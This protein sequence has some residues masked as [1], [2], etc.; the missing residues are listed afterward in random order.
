MTVA[1]MKVPFSGYVLDDDAEVLTAFMHLTA[2]PSFIVN[3]TGEMI[4]G[5]ESGLALLGIDALTTDGFSLKSVVH[6]DE[7]A[8]AK[9]QAQ[10]LLDGTSR[11]VH[12]E[13]RYRRQDGC[14]IWVSISLSLIRDP[15]G[16]PRY[17]CLQA[18]DIDHHKQLQTALDESERRWNFAL[19]SAG[20]GIWEA[21]RAQDQVYYSPTWKKLRGFD[22]NAIVKSSTEAWMA[23]VHPRD[24]ERVQTIVRQQNSGEIKRKA[25]E[26]RERH[27]LGH[28][29]WIQSRGA[30]IEFDVSGNPTRI[31]GTDTDITEFKKA[32]HRSR[33]LAHRLEL[34][35]EVSKI[36]VF[37]ADLETGALYYDDP[38]YKLFG[39]PLT[40]KVL[41]SN[42]FEGAL[43][44]DDATRIIADIAA[45]V[46]SR[47]TFR[48]KFRICR[49]D[50]SIRS[51][52]AHATYFEDSEG[53][54]K[55]IG[56]NWD[57][58]EDV[59]LAEGLQ[60]ANALAELR[61][62][63][64][65]LAKE[66]IERQALHDPLTGLPNRRYLEALLSSFA[67]SAGGHI[68]ALHID[69]DGFKKINDTLGH[70]A[71]DA[72]LKHVGEFL[73]NT[74][75]PGDFVCRVGG[76]E[77]TVICSEPVGHD[78]LTDLAER[79][80]SRLAA[81]LLY[82][83]H[84]CHFGCSIGIAIE[85]RKLLF[86]D[87][88]L[89]NADSA[90]YRAKDNGRGRV[91][92]FT[93]ALR[94]EIALTKRTADDLLRAIQH[95]EFVPYYQPVVDAK[96]YAIVGVE[97]LARWRHP[98]E[99]VLAPLR[100][101]KTAQDLNVL[102]RIDEQILF[103]AVTDMEHWRQQGLDIP[104]VSV[105]VSF[106]RLD[107]PNLLA[108]LA[109][110]AFKPDTLVFEFLESIF[111]DDSGDEF[112]ANINGI[113]AMGIG[114]DIDDFGTGHTSF[115]SLFRLKPRRFKIDRQLVMPII[116][117]ADQREIVKSIIG[118]GKTLGIEVVAEGVETMRHAEVLK[119]LGCDYLQGFA[120]AKPMASDELAA[121]CVR[122]FWP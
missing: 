82:Q 78:Y 51:V 44:P 98:S 39:I 114:I 91:E 46:E 32:E 76:D 24:R 13:R 117:H 105:N 6:T 110:L 2:V 70:A 47:G 100:F 60:A 92:F 87:R 33:A 42:D 12:S 18:I 120:F 29:I 89:I 8:S 27:Q 34:A 96:T 101:M 3:L 107:D 104:S 61:Y 83:G 102:A 94:A 55:L 99:G 95:E 97:A 28:Y 113:R 54:P 118:I 37:E 103:R 30:P 108:K 67:G 4:Y 1:T 23:R 15:A 106:K 86:A 10:A 84:L 68:A 38:L 111:L 56:A 122:R 21:D 43:H 20:Q 64:L 75:G 14:F 71:G 73:T 93:E 53:N 50:G 35:L 48:G 79:I 119:E 109:G 115:L 90:L 41:S 58:T 52:M 57:V 31:I 74:A 22:P 121:W 116:E 40:N 62:A 88:L 19:E 65:E 9:E 16:C 72:V 25:F 49:P 66:A 26:Y 17:F 69:L 85:E 59:A 45:A 5:N 112:E 81:P 7:A 11:F 80:I 63:E 36:G 77:F